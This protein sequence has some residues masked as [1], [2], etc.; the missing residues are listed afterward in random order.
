MELFLWGLAVGGVLGVGGKR[1]VKTLAKGYFAAADVATGAAKG[2]K[3]IA[4]RA[5]AN[6]REAIQEARRERD[7]KI[8]AEQAPRD[9]ED[10]PEADADDAPAGSEATR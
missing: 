6:F 4:G 3:Q 7:A 2:T 8:E 10:L 1:V 5:Q 9:L